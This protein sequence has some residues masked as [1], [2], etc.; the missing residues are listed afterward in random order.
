MGAP[1][2]QGVFQSPQFW[3]H[4]LFRV[5]T[6]IH[7]CSYVYHTWKHGF[8]Y[9]ELCVCCSQSTSDP[10]PWLEWVHASVYY[11][12]QPDSQYHLKT[13]MQSYMEIWVSLYGSVF[14]SQS[15]H[16]CSQS[17]FRMCTCISTCI[18]VHLTQNITSNPMH[19]YMETWVPLCDTMCVP[20]TLLLVPHL[21]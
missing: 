5:F 17:L 18:Y 10:T 4:T 3:S 7:T 9:V 11:L 16:F 19:S 21:D 2:W 8:L 15:S 20:V 1:V 6:Y 12:C 14:V 13:P